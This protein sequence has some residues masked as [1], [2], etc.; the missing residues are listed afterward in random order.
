[1]KII[2]AC[3]IL[4]NDKDHHTNGNTNSQTGDVDNRVIPITGQTSE[5][6]FEIVFKHAYLVFKNM[7][8]SL[9]VDNHIN[10]GVQHTKVFGYDAVIVRKW[11]KK[12][13]DEI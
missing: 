9:Q 10:Q 5:C 11:R 7:P 12:N 4:Y 1:V 13:C 6:G 8:F 3:L 2:E